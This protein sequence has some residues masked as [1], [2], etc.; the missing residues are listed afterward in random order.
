MIIS[1]N[2]CTGRGKVMTIKKLK[3]S[4]YI[5]TVETLYTDLRKGL[6]NYP[7]SP[8]NVKLL[9]RVTNEPVPLMCEQLSEAVITVLDEHELTSSNR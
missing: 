3:Y 9:L 2:G 7:F 5:E 4:L 6:I 8:L 1:F